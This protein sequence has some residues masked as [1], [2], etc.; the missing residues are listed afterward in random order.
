MEHVLGVV[1]VCLVAG[2]CMFHVF[3]L[4]KIIRGYTPRP[5]RPIDQLPSRPL[6]CRL[7]LHKWSVWSAE[8]LAK[9]QDPHSSMVTRLID[10][11]IQVRI[12]KGC[13]IKKER[14]VW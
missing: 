3:S 4:F 11:P 7:F 13:G 6:R 10:T 1:V 12:C 5:L 9:R 14:F 2:F 8:T